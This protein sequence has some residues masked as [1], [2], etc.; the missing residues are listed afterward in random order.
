M[1]SVDFNIA[2]SA[3]VRINLFVTRKIRSKKKVNGYKL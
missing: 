1:N 2:V 3:V